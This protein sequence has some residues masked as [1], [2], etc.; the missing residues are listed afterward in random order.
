MCAVA[1][2]VPEPQAPAAAREFLRDNLRAWSAP[3]LEEAVLLVSELASNVV[4]HAST[5][6]V[7]KVEWRDP[8]LRVEVSNGTSIV[9]AV[10]DLADENGGLGLRIV[11]AVA[12]EWGI[13]Q[14]ED[15]KAVWFTLTRADVRAAAPVRA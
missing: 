14:L 4:R 9:P 5:D 2:F 15:G 12:D 8:T 7:V 3:G 10:K 6:F 13:E 11:A 1:E